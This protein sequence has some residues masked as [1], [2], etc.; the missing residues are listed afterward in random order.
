[1]DRASSA[2]WPVGCRA[3]LTPASVRIEA[4]SP[5]RL[6]PFKDGIRIH[7]GRVAFDKSPQ[8]PTSFTVWVAGG[9]IEVLGRCFVV[10]Q[11]EDGEGT[12][13]LQRGRVAFFDRAGRK[14]VLE[15]SLRGWAMP[16]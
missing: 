4:Q 14:T 10:W 13:E 16:A 7:A 3:T 9:H 8:H 2:R 6:E 11:D 1:M 12:V 15:D 5:A